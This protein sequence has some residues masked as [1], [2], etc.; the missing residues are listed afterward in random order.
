MN[1]CC[2]VVVNKIYLYLHNIYICFINFRIQDFI[3][4]CFVI[5]GKLILELMDHSDM[6]SF[7]TFSPV[8]NLVLLSA[9]YDGTLKVWD[10]HEDGNMF[11]TLKMNNK[12]IYSCCWSPDAKTLVSV[13]MCKL[14]SVLIKFAINYYFYI[15]FV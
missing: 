13:G 9:S 3:N 6:V 11:Q 15:R 14:V 5:L 7:L 10:L 2:N 4:T 1:F 12:P 8:G